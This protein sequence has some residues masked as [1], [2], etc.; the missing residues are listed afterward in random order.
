[1]SDTY[2]FTRYR[3][4]DGNITGHGS[5]PAAYA[6]MQPRAGDESVYVGAALL[7]STHYFRNRQPVAYTPEQ[8]AS[9]A[10][11]PLHA[12]RWCNQAMQWLDERSDAQRAADELGAVH[13]ARRNAYPP[14]GDQLDCLWKAMHAGLLPQI[15]PFYSQI[16]SVKTAHPLPDQE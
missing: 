7:P 11:R 3:D 5:M 8:A 9:K 15:E 16:A 2:A 14:V 4:A 1:M 12:A 13:T 6:A 10:A